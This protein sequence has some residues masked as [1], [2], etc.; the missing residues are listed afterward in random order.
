MCG[1]AGIFAYHTDAPLVD[2][3][4][5]LRIREAMVKRGPDGAGLWVSNDA[6]VGLA[7]RRLAIIDLSEAGAQ[8]MATVD[9][10]FRVT[11]NG[12]IYNYRELRKELEAKGYRFRSNSD[13]EVLLHL[14]AEH[15]AE[16]VH[17][18]RGMYAFGIWDERNRT[19]FLAR[20][21][22]GIKPLYYADDGTT[23]RFASQVKALLCGENI[24]RE[25][26]SAG[27]VGFFVWGAVPEPFTLY[28]GIS[29]L[30]AGTWTRI[31][32]RGRSDAV[33]H[34]DLRKEILATQEVRAAVSDSETLAQMREAIR[35]SVR[36][37]MVSDVPVSAFLS[38][39]LDSAMVTALA[40]EFNAGPLST[41]TLG[42]S[43]F[44]GTEDDETTLA[45]MTAQRLGVPHEVSWV[46][47]RNFGEEMFTI[48]NQMDQPS[49]DG[50]NTYFVAKLAAERGIKVA[51][52]GLGGDELFGGYPSF[53]QVPLLAKS[54][55]P[56]HKVPA[57]GVWLRRLMA[58]FLK[59]MTSPKYASIFEYGGDI[60]GAYLLRR[61]LY[62]PWELDDLMDPETVEEGWD[63]LRTHSMLAATVEG[64]QNNKMAISTLETAW[65]M[66]NQ[67]LR[68][69]D[70]AG[71]AH[72]LEIRVPFVDIDLFRAALPLLAP[73]KARNKA[74]IA[75]QVSPNLP[76]QILE[77][78]KTG[79][80]VPVE[81]WLE[82]LPGSKGRG[83]GLRKWAVM[84]NP[85]SPRRIRI[86]AL[87][88]DAYGS[89]GGIAKFNRDLLRALSGMPRC[90][91]LTAFPRLMPNPHGPLPA[92]LTYD[93]SGLGGKFQYVWG[94][95]R[96]ILAHHH[97]GLIVCGHINLV[98]FAWLLSKLTH[99]PWLYI[100]HGIDAWQPTQSWITNR[101]IGAAD[102]VI[103]VS[104]VTRR[105]L[106][107]WSGLSLERIA[108]LPNSI[109]LAE[110]APR[111]RRADLARQ[112]GIE[113]KK[114][115]MT[116]G[117]LSGKE[118]YKGFDEVIEVMPDV[119]KDE[120]LS[121]YLIVGDGDDRAR[122]EEKAA[123]LGLTDR[124]IFAG[125]VSEEEKADCYALADAYVMPS[126]GEGFGIVLLEAMACGVPTVGSKI[127]GGREAL[128]GGQLGNL[129]DPGNLQEIRAATL[130][131]LR[132]TRMR[133]P[134]LEYFS[135]E[136][137]TRRARTLIAEVVAATAVSP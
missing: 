96:H 108:I 123:Q 128:I 34:F 109:D 69:A 33:R 130:A 53:S 93:V 102:R 16:M 42:F 1:I 7:H 25:A 15:G 63:R 55:R 9:G 99:A 101:L 17:R 121:V 111:P 127:D 113:G 120:P 70:W 13:T 92:G 79:F 77:R 58:P 129:V 117:R 88:T 60:A 19:L 18:L 89:H 124:V 97:Y 67:L 82:H 26:D 45:K 43:E 62:L 37:H 94:I 64:I 2:R 54:L 90:R 76:K 23:L 36:R 46:T 5:L 85:P 24:D 100:V 135:Y 103:S 72:S 14:Y 80:R 78:R 133:P 6:R 73:G 3:D 122:L 98:P 28:R 125:F 136:N 112:Y 39:G 81:L 59:G 48:L 83:R 20:D 49:T 126:H 31:S 104:D 61:A 27:H 137:F 29:Q 74:A 22:F 52:S 4:E 65:Y 71:M 47:E 91:G 115:I 51:L 30:P 44:A 107:A 11:F 119:L 10:N 134:G 110:F 8:P 132:H 32:T 35:D 116:L 75:A 12:E 118:R 41:V 105:R 56:F 131:A 50:V 114:V 95:F 21:P 106:M 68:D 87:V 57:L 84:V 66:R 86:L 40:S 38:A